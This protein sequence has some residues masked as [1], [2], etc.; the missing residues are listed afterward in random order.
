MITFEHEFEADFG[1]EPAIGPTL[2]RAA[3][4]YHERTEAFDQAHCQARDYRG[5]AIPHGPEMGIC[6][7]H[8]RAVLD[9][10]VERLRKQGLTED[11]LWEAI[12]VELPHFERDWAAGV[13]QTGTPP[14]VLPS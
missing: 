7:Q 8:A 3:R 1:D 12:S 5:F 6:T 14:P 11:Q 4:E 9:E 13:R 2:R 10:L